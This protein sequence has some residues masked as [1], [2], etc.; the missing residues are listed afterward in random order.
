[1]NHTL[2]RTKLTLRK[3]KAKGKGHFKSLGSM[4]MTT[5]KAIQIGSLRRNKLLYKLSLILCIKVNQFN[6]IPY[7]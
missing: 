4:R 2:I 1:M 7:K 5:K 3:Q 6:N